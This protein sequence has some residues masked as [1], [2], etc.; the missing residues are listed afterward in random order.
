MKGFAVI[1]F[2]MLFVLTGCGG[3]NTLPPETD[4]V[5][6]REVLKTVLDAWVA[7]KSMEDVKNGS[8]SIIARDP[9]WK[10]GHKLMKYEVADSEDRKGVDLVLSVKLF[11]SKAGAPPQEK[12]VKFTVG[13]GSSTVCMR[14]E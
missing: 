5:R 7:G 12:N 6:G 1:G 10:A 8:P 4:N 9:D 3:T 11:I 2:G 13:I 14:Q